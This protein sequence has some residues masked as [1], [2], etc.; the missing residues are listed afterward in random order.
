MNEMVKL[1]QDALWLVL[2]LSL[3]PVVIATVAG[4]LVAIVQAATQ[5][6]EQTLPF[7][8]KLFVIMLVLLFM[9]SFFTGVLVNFSN[10][11]F[12]DFPVL[13]RR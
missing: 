6:Q 9:A 10:R 7:A 5:I 1:T 8:V 11:L 13:V 12:T 4:L 2:V 3:P